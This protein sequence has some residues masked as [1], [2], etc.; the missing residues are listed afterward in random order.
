MSLNDLISPESVIAPLRAASSK[1]ALQE[2]SE[3]AASLCGVP[4]RVISD[5]IRQRERLGATG[6]GGGIAIPHA[7][8]LNIPS[9]FA[10]FARLE[11][12]VDFASRDGIPV[13][14]I[15]MLIAPEFAGA[16]HLKALSRIARVLHEPAFV[17]RLR[18]AKDAAAL[19]LLLTQVPESR[20]A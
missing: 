13:D 18:G 1:Q 15:C 5:A 9:I 6:V 12:P 8:I 2:M 7:K 11:K 17:T 3:R 4:S 10:V 16:D 20:A 19:Y 14:L